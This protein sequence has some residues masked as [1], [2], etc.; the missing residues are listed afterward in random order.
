MLNQ[1][2]ISEFWSDDFGKMIRVGGALGALKFFGHLKRA[3]ELFI[4]VRMSPF[5]TF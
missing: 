2:A 4:S 3:L 5:A 1:M